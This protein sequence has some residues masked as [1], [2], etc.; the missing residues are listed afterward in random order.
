MQVWAGVKNITKFA[1]RTR[2]ACRRNSFES[3]GKNV[4]EAAL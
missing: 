4:F 2:I 3:I 1:T